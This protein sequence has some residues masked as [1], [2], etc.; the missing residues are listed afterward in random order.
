[1]SSL[2]GIHTFAFFHT[3]M[4]T[5]YFLGPLTEFYHGLHVAFGTGS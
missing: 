3:L 2:F 4:P 1:M 5:L